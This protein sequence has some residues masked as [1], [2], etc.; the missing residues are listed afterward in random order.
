MPTAPLRPVTANNGAI[1]TSWYDIS[2]KID[3][4]DVNIEN[5]NEFLEK[6]F[7]QEELAESV[8]Q[9]SQYIEEET[10]ELGSASKVFLGG[11]S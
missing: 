8:A 6:A 7:G 4:M 3:K 11:F 10:L 5:Y 2:G 1:G 9:I